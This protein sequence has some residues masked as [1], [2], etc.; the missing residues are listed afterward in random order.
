MA[1]MRVAEVPV[2]P[3][4]GIGE[5]SSMRVPKVV[6]PITWLLIRL[7]FKRLIHKYIISDGHPAAFAYILSGLFLLSSL[8]LMLYLVVLFLMTGLIMKVALIASVAFLSI[9]F[10]L[11]F[12][13][14]WMDYEANRH[15]F[16]FLPPHELGLVCN[17]KD[18]P[19]RRPLR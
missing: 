10:Q 3:L 8:A 6:L 5:K 11:L 16:I 15:L 9:S 2:N 4:Y 12:T 17:P 18:S 19:T 13:Y 1:G 7:F 14:F